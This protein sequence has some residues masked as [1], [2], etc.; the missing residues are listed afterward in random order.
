MLV[1]ISRIA[2]LH[3]RA[4]SM[5]MCACVR[6]SLVAKSQMCMSEY[7]FWGIR[8]IITG[9]KQPL[10]VVWCRPGSSTL[11]VNSINLVI[12]SIV[13][14]WYDCCWAT[15][16]YSVC[17]C[18]RTRVWMTFFT[19]GKL[20]IRHGQFRQQQ[21]HGSRGQSWTL[22]RPRHVAGTSW[23]GA[24]MPYTIPFCSWYKMKG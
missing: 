16:T 17:V 6:V 11:I 23:H 24:L 2:Y 14:F 1:S 7:V 21:C 4:Y 15:I 12:C 5:C 3:A 13:P 20:A 9:Q 8:G 22:Q 18:A 19:T 10:R